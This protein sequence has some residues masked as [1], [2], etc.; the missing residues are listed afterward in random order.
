M[1]IELYICWDI[2]MLTQLT[3]FGLKNY[4]D[5]LTLFLFNLISYLLNF[6]TLFLN[7]TLKKFIM[8]RMWD[9]IDLD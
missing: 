5:F 3:D 2:K 6:L 1:Y 7:L 4:W 9:G 8:L